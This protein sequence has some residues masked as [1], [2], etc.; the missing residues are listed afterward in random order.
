MHVI[1][2]KAVAFKEALKPEF[3]TY[4]KQVITN[5]KTLANTLME[6]GYK[7][8]SNGTDNHLILVDLTNKNIT[9]K[10]AELALGKAGITVNKNAIPFDTQPPMI[11]SG[12]RIGTAALTTR[13]FKENEM[14]QIAIW[15]DKAITHYKDEAYLQKIYNEVL[16]L[17]KSKPLF[18]WS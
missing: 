2:A 13:G 17:T 5:A 9:G 12:I 8:V 15:I 10:D 3:K 11:T 7:L 1:A 18:S 16:E 4:A 14:Q 6:K